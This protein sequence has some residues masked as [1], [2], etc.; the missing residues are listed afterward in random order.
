LTEEIV[1]VWLRA[2]Q[3][4][5]K[6]RS[7]SRKPSPVVSKEQLTLPK[8]SRLSLLAQKVDEEAERTARRVF[9]AKRW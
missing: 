5:Q 8:P 9:E 1:S 3:S 6:K 4:R 7:V 2:K